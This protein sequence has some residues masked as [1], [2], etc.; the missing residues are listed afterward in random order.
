MAKHL[1]ELVFYGREEAL[2][3]PAREDGFDDLTDALRRLSAGDRDINAYYPLEV[4]DQVSMLVSIKHIQTMRIV[5]IQAGGGSYVPG[6]VEGMEFY[7]AA[8]N[9]PISI[10]MD[11]TGPIHDV[12]IAMAEATREEGMPGCVMLSDREGNPFLFVP[13]DVQFILMDRAYVD[14]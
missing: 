5:T 8:R 12:L 2:A 9:A 6:Q 1:L 13:N 10:D 3:Y 11:P 14:S 7:L 4:S